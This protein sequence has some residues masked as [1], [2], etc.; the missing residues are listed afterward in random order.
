MNHTRSNIARKTRITVWTN[1][2]EELTIYCANLIQYRV[3]LAHILN[4]LEMYSESVICWRVVNAS[5]VA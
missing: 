4:A 3:N 5:T 2:E 1:K